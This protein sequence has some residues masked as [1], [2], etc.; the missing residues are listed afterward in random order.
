LTDAIKASWGVLWCVQMVYC[1]KLIGGIGSS[2][3]LWFRSGRG[4]IWGQWEH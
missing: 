1:T 3:W 4:G 2:I